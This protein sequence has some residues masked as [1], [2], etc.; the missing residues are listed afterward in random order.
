MTEPKDIQLMGTE[1]RFLQRVV[2]YL[3]VAFG[4]PFLR[5][6]ACVWMRES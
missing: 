1:Q 2:P 5:K 6:D 3:A 4:C